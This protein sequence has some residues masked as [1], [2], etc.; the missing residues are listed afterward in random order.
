MS[1]VA[2]SKRRLKR[3]IIRNFRTIGPKG[4]SVDLDEIV[5]LVGPNNAGKS[6]I[7][8]AYNVIM[9]DEKLSL[10]DFPNKIISTDANLRPQIELETVVDEESKPS[11]KWIVTEES[12]QVVREKWTWDEPGKGKRFGFLVSESRWSTDDDKEKVPWGAANVAKAGRP[13]PHL[14]SAFDTPE[15]QTEEIIKIVTEALI[16]K[17]KQPKNVDGKDI[18]SAFVQLTSK[19]KEAQNKIVEESRGEI[20]KIEND[21]SRVIS[22]IFPK[23]VIKISAD[24]EINPEKSIKLFENKPEL[25]MGHEAGFLSDV[26]KQGSG[27]RRTLLWSAL[28]IIQESKV[29]SEKSD[30]PQVLLI[31]EPEICL[32]PSAIRECSDIL[33]DL[34]KGHGW[35]VMLTTHSPIFVDTSKDNTT[36]VRVSRDDDGEIGSTT[37]FRPNKAKLSNDD[38]ENLKLLNLCDPYVNEFF[39]GGRVILVEGDTEFSCFKYIQM[40]EPDFFKNL[41]IVRAR[42]KANLVSLMKVLN[43]FSSRYAVLHDADT[44]TYIDKN[45]KT[46]KNSAWTLNEKIKDHSVKDISLVVA[47]L[48][49]FETALLSKERSGDKP[50]FAVEDIKENNDYYKNVRELLN[51]LYSGAGQLPQNS[52][53]WDKIEDLE[54]S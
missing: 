36:I 2:S 27:A 37:L 49:N 11:D 45:G 38:K 43:Q 16:S 6:S 21:L 40:Q 18:E 48:T 22:K 29:K 28:R 32:H 54:L 10:D 26:S 47:N 25:L 24:Q 46:K 8:K 1:S 53:V 17:L 12:E 34:P 9:S 20:E 23:H 13:L 41:H 52:K 42:G 30:R 15:K 44:K 39:F 14:V 35:Q 7:L 51:F 4:I 50:Y 31:D 5:V 33:Y 19:I 3:I